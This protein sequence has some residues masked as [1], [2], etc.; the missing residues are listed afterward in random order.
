MGVSIDEVGGKPPACLA[1][2]VVRLI[3]LSEHEPESRDQKVVKVHLF[4]PTLRVCG[5]RNFG[6]WRTVNF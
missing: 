2:W 1:L 3:S 6:L 5:R 4:G